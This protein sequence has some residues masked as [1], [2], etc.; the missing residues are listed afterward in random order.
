MPVRHTLASLVAAGALLIS[1]CGGSSDD[2]GDPSEATTPTALPMIATVSLPRPDSNVI[3]EQPACPVEQELC[4]FAERVEPLVRAGRVD[5]LLEDSPGVPLRC[6]NGVNEGLDETFPLCDGA[7]PGEV[8]YGFGGG[9]FQAEGFTVDLAGTREII[10]GWSGTPGLGVFTIGCKDVDG[11][12]QCDDMFTLVL[13]TSDSDERPFLGLVIERHDGRNEIVATYN[14]RA[15]DLFQE[16]V[17][18][19]VTDIGVDP[20]DPTTGPTRF[21]R[22]P[23]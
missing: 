20:L 11:T 5:E 19:G 17:Q 1:A 23:H 9:T 10:A 7:A 15:I 12:P 8:R 21:V 16:Y 18:G 13:S 3:A 14:G 6:P 2:G 22:L 4:A